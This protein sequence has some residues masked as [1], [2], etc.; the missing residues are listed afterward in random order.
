MLCQI[1]KKNQYIIAFL[2]QLVGSNIQIINSLNNLKGYGVVNLTV[3]FTF[4]CFYQTSNTK[5]AGKFILSL[6]FNIYLPLFPV[7][8][9]STF[10]SLM[11]VSWLSCLESNE[12]V[13][14]LLSSKPPLIQ[15]LSK[16]DTTNEFP[17]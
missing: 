13:T 10:C 16:L 3:N 6:L 2:K 11:S 14:I 4:H 8:S 7:L 17:V 9:V 5:E 1:L 12:S 15:S